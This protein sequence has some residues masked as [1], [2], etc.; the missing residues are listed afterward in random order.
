MNPPRNVSDRDVIRPDVD[1]WAEAQKVIEWGES[2]DG[3][4][5][6]DYLFNLKVSLANGTVNGKRFGLV[7]S[8]P[9]AFRK[10]EA[11]RVEKEAIQVEATPVPVTSDRIRIE[12]VVLKVDVKQGYGYNDTRTVITVLDDRGFK[13]WGTAPSAI[14]RNVKIQDRVAF[15]AAVAPS[16]RDETFGFFSR[17]TKPEHTFGP[18]HEEN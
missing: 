4:T 13:V 7:V 11:K 3:N 6:S 1:D 5:S 2:I 9:A 15:D 12:G 18:N 8:A 17:P 16:Q 10:Q 14:R